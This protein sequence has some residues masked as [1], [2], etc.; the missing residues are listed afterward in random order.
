MAFT[1]KI[2]Q[3]KLS[4]G[5]LLGLSDD[6]GNLA[7]FIAINKNP[8]CFCLSLVCLLHWPLSN[9]HSEGQAF[10]KYGLFRPRWFFSRPN[11]PGLFGSL[12]QILYWPS[13]NIDFVCLS[14]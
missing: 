10:D 4:L 9:L 8:G 12:I 13:G 7:G 2:K 5:C 11:E 3:D 1:E 14:R 6:L